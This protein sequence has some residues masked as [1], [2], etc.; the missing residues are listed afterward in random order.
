M[1]GNKQSYRFAGLITVFE[2]EAAT[3]ELTDQALVALLDALLAEHLDTRR[4]RKA[5]S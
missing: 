4:A 5:R 2:G 1:P 3:L